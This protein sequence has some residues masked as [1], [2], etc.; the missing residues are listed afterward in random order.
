LKDGHFE[1]LEAPAALVSHPSEGSLEVIDDVIHEEEAEYAPS[2]YLPATQSD[3]EQHSESYRDETHS[4]HSALH[5]AANEQAVEEDILSPELL[6]DG[7]GLDHK[8]EDEVEDANRSIDE[9]YNK[10]I[11]V[12]SSLQDTRKGLKEFHQETQDFFS[13]V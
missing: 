10:T 13:K 3:H 9:T 2:P 12:L 6:V 5:E 7:W 4:V 1:M 11:D 8:H